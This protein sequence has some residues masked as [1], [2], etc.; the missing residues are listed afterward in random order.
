MASDC[1]RDTADC[2]LWQSSLVLL[3]LAVSGPKTVTGGCGSNDKNYKHEE[4]KCWY[5]LWYFWFIVVLVFITIVI[6]VIFYCKQQVKRSTGRRARRR[7]PVLTMPIA[8][9]QYEA[10]GHEPPPYHIAMT[11]CT[12][13]DSAASISQVVPSSAAS[14]MQQAPPSLPGYIMDPG[15]YHAYDNLSMTSVTSMG[16]FSNPP[17]YSRP[18]SAFQNQAQQGDITL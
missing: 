18:P 8:P 14:S 1:G 2:F 16:A 5:E 15:D 11:T 6:L 9:P 7:T 3:C 4:N 10:P 17:P 13:P 12:V